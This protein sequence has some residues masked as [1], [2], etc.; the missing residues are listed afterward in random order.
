VR[1]EGKT[2]LAHQNVCS[3]SQLEWPQA[4]VTNGH[5]R[6]DRERPPA[7]CRTK[8]PTPQRVMG[9]PS[10]AKEAPGRLRHKC[11]CRQM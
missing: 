1:V 2:S 5:D 8:V 10:G 9:G 6:N 11:A 3:R 4:I 7:T